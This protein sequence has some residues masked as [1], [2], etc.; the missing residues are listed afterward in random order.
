MANDPAWKKVLGGVCGIAIVVAVLL[1]AR[2][3]GVSG[4]EMDRWE[5]I[6]VVSA[7]AAGGVVLFMRRRYR[8]KH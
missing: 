5:G 8:Q 7:A 3:R 6:L 2:A 1:I 4:A